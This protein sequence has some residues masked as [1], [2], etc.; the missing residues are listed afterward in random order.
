MVKNNKQQ[1]FNLALSEE[2]NERDLIILSQENF[3]I[4]IFDSENNKNT[5]EYKFKIGEKYVISE[6][7]NLGN[8]MKKICITLNKD[9]S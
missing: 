2:D 6:N 3:I 4:D 7:L 9:N 8:S 5:H 1:C